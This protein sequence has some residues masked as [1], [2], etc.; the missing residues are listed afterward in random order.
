MIS[1]ASARAFA[2]RRIVASIYFPGSWQC[3]YR[4]LMFAFFRA[5]SE[6]KKDRRSID[7]TFGIFKVIHLHY[8]TINEAPSA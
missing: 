7:P 1:F 6:R 2:L 5:L 8:D 3:D 4:Y